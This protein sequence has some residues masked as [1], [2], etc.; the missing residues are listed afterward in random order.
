[1]Y[2]VVMCRRHDRRWVDWLVDR[3]EVASI[4]VFYFFDY[5][6]FLFLFCNRSAR[7]APHRADDLIVVVAGATERI[8]V[9]FKD[10]RRLF[11]SDGGGLT[12]LAA[13]SLLTGGSRSVRMGI[14]SRAVNVRV[15]CT[16]PRGR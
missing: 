12:L 11:R 1:M 14:V 16:S 8:S 7:A 4:F 15:V 5:F 13:H 9:R 3:V 10:G 6:Y 2:L